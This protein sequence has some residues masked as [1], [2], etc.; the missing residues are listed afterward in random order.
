LT[1]PKFKAYGGELLSA[2]NFTGNWPFLRAWP[3]YYLPRKT[4]VEHLYDVGDATVPPGEVMGS[5]S[6]ESA[7]LIVEDIK[8]RIPLGSR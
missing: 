6:A 5:G 1:I 4:P 7:R 3:G 2:H 8:K